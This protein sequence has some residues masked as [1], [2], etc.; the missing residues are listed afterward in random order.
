MAA[1][2]ECPNCRHHCAVP[3]GRG[4]ARIECPNCASTFTFTRVKNA[5][6]AP[7]P[8]SAHRRAS[9]P[10]ADRKVRRRGHVIRLRCP[11]CE[12]LV[13][14]C[15]KSGSK[16]RRR[17][18][19]GAVIGPAEPIAP[20]FE[21]SLEESVE[22]AIQELMHESVAEPPSAP[23]PPPTN[24]L[25]F[26]P[27]PVRT[28]QRRKPKKSEEEESTLRPTWV[29]SAAVIIVSLG[30]ISAVVPGLA[31]L[32]LP[33]AA[34]GLLAAGYALTQTLRSGSSINYA[35]G[36]TAYGFFVLVIAAA[37]PGCLGPRY[38]EF[39][40]RRVD[41]DVTRVIPREGQSAKDIPRNPDWVDASKYALQR[42]NVFVEVLSVRV[43][44]TPVVDGGR[45][46]SAECVLVSL[47][48]R[49]TG[50]L[51]QVDHR[52]NAPVAS[53]VEFDVALTDAAGR[54]LTRKMLDPATSVPSTT[55]GSGMF[56]VS[57]T[58]LV[59]AFAAPPADADL[60]LE[61]SGGTL[62]GPPMRFTIPKSMIARPRAGR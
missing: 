14:L 18:L 45:L 47:R 33:L 32:V 60:R 39:R 19:V 5:T 34:L 57:T 54:A 4:R 26:S 62:E 6:L 46:S 11:H 52:S 29:N 36:A 55:R 56:P 44:K 58:D 35:A 15:R 27:P 30:L 25:V 8:S 16:K 10:R 50:D 48:V 59:V 41:P 43:G 20:A 42:K 61:V 40:Q 1:A 31:V 53:G 12:S 38:H 51:S 3:P 37:F 24:P 28:P 23:P 22:Q 2:V 49:N 7:P 21:E 17:E 13:D 9:P